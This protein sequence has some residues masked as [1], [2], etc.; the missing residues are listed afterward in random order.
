[1]NFK[2]QFMKIGNMVPAAF[3]FLAIFVA[4]LPFASRAQPAPSV[5][6]FETSEGYAPGALDGQQGWSVTQGLAAITSQDAS[7]GSQSVVLLPDTTRAK[8]AQTFTSFAGEN[9]VYVDFYTKPVVEINVNDSTIFDM[10]GARIS[11]GYDGSHNRVQ[12]MYGDGQGG[13]FW[14]DLAP[15]LS[16]DSNHQTQDWIRLTARLDFAHQTWDV[17]VNGQMLFADIPFSDN[18]IT[19]FTSFVATGDAAASSGLDHLN[20]STVNPMFDDTN[21]DGIDDA[22]EQQYGMNLSVDDRSDDPDNDGY[23]NVWEYINGTS[24]TDYYNDAL[25]V[26]RPLISSNG[27]LGPQGLATVLVTDVYGYPLNN[28]PLVFSVTSGISQLSATPGGTA[29]TQMSVNTNSAGLAQAYVGFI[30][31]SSDTLAVTAQSGSQTEMVP[32]GINSSASTFFYATDF[33]NAEGYTVGS[34]DGQ[35]GW[36]VVQ[37][38]ASVTDQSSSSGSQSIVL[39]PGAIPS[40]IIRAFPATTGENAIYVSFFAQPVAETSIT[41][42][43]SF[44][45]GGARFAFTLSDPDHAVLQV[46]NGDGAGGGSWAR[47]LFTDPVDSSSHQL[48]DMVH[49]TVRLDFT[50]KRWD[51]YT[52]NNGGMAAA[53]LGFRDNSATYLSSFAVTGDAGAPTMIDDILIAPQNPLFA[54]V[55]NDGIDDPWEQQYGLSLSTDDREGDPDG[56]GIVNVQEYVRGSDPTRFNLAIDFEASEGYALGSLDGQQ[57]WAVT[58]GSAMVTGQYASSGSHSIVLQPST[59]TVPPARIVRTFSAVTG[60]NVVYVDFYTT[61]DVN[62]K[63][64]IATGAI[65]DIG[66]ARFTFQ[67]QYGDGPDG[68]LYAFSGNGAGGGRW[69]DSGYDS[70]DIGAPGNGRWIHFTVRLDYT[71]ETW[72]LY[73]DGKMYLADMGLRDASTYL[74]SFAVTGSTRSVNF[75]T[76]PIYL[77][78]ISITSANPLFADANN[79]GINDAWEQQYGLSLASD[80]R[81]VSPNGSQTVLQ[82]Y[83]SGADPYADYYNGTLPGL[84]SLVDSSGVPGPQGLV[85]VLVTGSTGAPLANAPLIFRVASGTAWIAATPGGVGSTQVMVTTNS[86][87]VAQAYASFVSP[88]GPAVLD[89]IAQSGSQTTSLPIN[90]LP[91]NGSAL[92]PPSNLTATALSST[93]VSLGW[94]APAILGETYLIERS[95]DGV[96]FTQAAVPDADTAGYIDTGLAAG[97]SYFYRIWAQG[98]AGA[99]GYSNTVSVTTPPNGT[100][101]PL[102]PPQGVVL[103]LKADT[104]ISRVNGSGV[105]I[106]PDQSGLGNDAII[107]HSSNHW[108]PPS[109]E[110]TLLANGQNGRPVVH[111]SASKQQYFALPN[112]MMS[113]A[114]AGE[115]FVV[116]RA[117]SNQSS[118]D[119]PI[120]LLG[121]DG[122]SSYGSGG[123]GYPGYNGRLRE[124][125]GTFSGYDVGVP[126][127]DLTT[128]NL[129]NISSSASSW[130]ARL[131][132]SALTVYGQD[133]RT[134][135]YSPITITNNT[136]DFPPN[137]FLGGYVNGSFDGDIAEVIVYNRVLSTAERETVRKYLS[138]RY[139]L[140]PQPP[141]FSPGPGVYGSPFSVTLTPIPAGATIYYTT[142]GSDPSPSTSLVYGSPISVTGLTH[143]KAIGVLN[144]QTSGIADGTFNV[145]LPSRPETPTSGFAATYYHASNFSGSTISRL[146]PFIN[147]PAGSSIPAGVGSAVWTGT[148]TAQFT[149]S[150]TFNITSD[151]NPRLWVGGTLVIDGSS[152]TSYQKLSGTIS[153]VQGQTYPVRLEYVVRSSNSSAERLSLTWS[154][155]ANFAEESVPL[156]QVASGLP[157]AN[158]AST[159]SASPAG[160]SLLDGSGVTLSTGTPSTAHIYYTLD[161]SDPTNSS[162]L[163]TAPIVLHSSVTIKARA[164][165][166]SYNDSGVL[167]ASY[168]VDRTGPVL[169]SLTFNN[170]AVPGVI[171]VN[172][173]LGITATSNVGVQRVEFRLDGQLI[174]TDT[175]AA[176][177]FTVPIAILPISDGSHALNIQAWD[178]LGLASD[179]FTASITTALPSPAAPVITAPADGTKVNTNSITV[180]GTA[181]KNSLV[182]VYDG[183]NSVGTGSAGANGVFAINVPLVAGANQLKATAQNRNP[184]PSGFSTVI[185]VTYDNA[186]P[187]PPSAVSALAGAGGTVQLSWHQPAG[188]VAASG[189]YLFRSTAPIPGDAVI[190]PANALGGLL[191]GLS[192]KDTPP[193]DG[194]YYYRLVTSHAVGTSETL[195][196]LSNQVD[197][198]ADSTPPSATGS[199]QPMGSAF[200]AAGHRLG[201]GL[202]QVTLTASEPLGATPFFNFSIAGGGAIAVNLSAAGNNTYT[203]LFTISSSTPSG[204]LTPVFSAIDAV[205][206]RGSVITLDVPWAIDTAGPKATGLTPVQID[207]S[208]TVQDLP[209][210]DAIRN[211]PV[212]PATAVT[213]SWRLTLDEAPKSGTTPVC[214]ATLSGHPNLTLPVTVAG[215]SDG[216]LHTW[217]LTLTLPSDAGS[218]TE[219]L[220]LAYTVSD[221]LGNIGSTITSPHVFQVY[222]GNL[223]PLAVPSGLAATA[224]PAGAIHLAWNAI[225]TASAYVLQVKGPTDTDFH[226]LAVPTG[227]TTDYLYT[228]SADGT[229]SYQIASVRSE[230]GQDSNSGWS[231]PVSARSD[232]VPPDAPT[233]F[234]LQ[235]ISQ[236]VKASWTTPVN[237]PEDVAGYAL[238]RSA[239]A[240]TSIDSLTP[241]LANIP[242]AAAFAVDSSPNGGMPYYALVAFDAAGNRSV[243]VTG[244]A[245]VGLLPVRTLHVAQTDQAAPVLSWQQASGSVIDGY[246]LLVNNVLVSV[247]GSTLLPA[248]S[249][250]YTDQNYQSGDRAYTVRTVSGPSSVNRSLVLPGV[251]IS[252][253]SDAKIIRGLVGTINVIVQNLSTTTSITDAH[254]DLIVAGRHHGAA[255]LI[256][257][258]PGAQQTVPVVVGGYADVPSGTAPVSAVLT[259]MPNDGEQVTLTRSLN[260]NVME[261]AFTAQIIPTNMV[262]GGAGSITFQLTNPSDQPI[263]FKVAAQSGSQPSAE[264]RIQ[265]QDLRGS[266]LSTTPLKIVLGDDVVL[267]PDGTTVVRIPAG[268]T[269]VSPPIQVSIPLNA[270][271]VVNVALGI[272]SVYY[273]FGESDTQVTLDGPSVVAQASTRVAPY[274]GQITSITP[275][276]SSGMAPIV[277]QGRALWSGIDP[278]LPSALAT[279]V[280]LGLYIKNGGFVL[281][282]TVTT[283]SSGNFSYTYQPGAAEKGGVYSVWA[284]HPTVTA[285]PDS[286]S[287]FTIT[288]IIVSPQA[289]NL[290]TPRNYTQAI[291]VQVS[292]GP[293]TTV[294]NL[295]AEL[296][297]TL[298]EAV[299]VTATP[300]ATVGQNQTLTLP[301]SIVG[302]APTVTSLDSG[303]LNFHVVSDVPGGGEL[304]WATV[305]VDYQFSNAEPYLQATPS[306]LQIG[307][308]PGSVGS[309]SLDLKNAGLS[310]LDSATFSLVSTDGSAVPSWIRL[311]SP[312]TLGSLDVGAD[313]NAIVTVAP[314]NTGQ[315]ID[316]VYHLNLHVSADNDTQN[317]PVT[318]TVSPSGQGGAIFHLID[319][320]FHFAMP[321]GSSNPAFDGLPGA[322]ISL[323][324]ESSDGIPTFSQGATTDSSGE[325]S[326]SNLPAGSYKLRITADKH[327]PYTGR[328]TV[329]PGVI[330]SQQILLDYSP[331]SF[332]WT[333]V[334]VTIQDTYNIVL[335]A[336]YETKVP[337]PVVILEPAS[338]TLPPMCAGQTATGEFRATN[339]GLIDAQQ[340]TIQVPPNDANFSYELSSNFG[341]RIPAGQ[342]VTITYKVT[343]LQP[344]PGKCPAVSASGGGDGG[345]GNCGTYVAPGSVNSVDPCA[346]GDTTNCYTPFFFTAAWGACAPPPPGPGPGPGAASIGPGS[347][348]NLSGP[349]SFGN[350]VGGAGGSGDPCPP[351]PGPPPPPPPPPPPNPPPPNPPPPPCQTSCCQGNNGGPPPPDNNHL[352]PVKSWVDLTS[353][354]FCD[355]ATDLL[356]VV[357]DGHVSVWRD[358]SF[359]RWTFRTTD[360][361]YAL[362]N[363]AQNP[364]VCA[365]VINGEYYLNPA[366]S[367][368]LSQGTTIGVPQYVEGQTFLELGGTRPGKIQA[369]NGLFVWTDGTGNERDYDP[370]TAHLV[371]VRLRGLVIANYSY[372]GSGRL[373]TV[374]DRNGRTVFTFAYSGSSVNPASVTDVTGRQ[375]G[376]TYD[377]VGRL[378]TVTDVVGTV[379]T[380]T[381]DNWSNIT[382]KQTHIAD[383]PTSQDHIETVTYQL[384]TSMPA[385]PTVPPARVVPGSSYFSDV[386]HGQVI[387]V[388]QNTGRELIINYHYNSADQTYYVKTTTSE[389]VVTEFVFD[390]NSNLLSKLVNGQQVYAMQQDATTRVIARGSNQTTEQYDSLGNVVRRIYPDQTFEAYEYDP[391]VNRVS[392]YT[393]QLGTVTT[394]T[395]DAMGNELTRTEAVGT[396]LERVTTNTY[397]PGTLHLKLHTDPLGRQTEYEYDSA[398]HVVHEYDPA[399]PAHQ[400]TYTYDAL[401]YMATQTDALGGVTTYGHDSSGLL[402]SETDP[403]QQQT[404]Y[405]YQGANLV[406]VETGRTTSAPGRIMRYEYDAEGRRTKEKRVDAQGVETV[407]K[408]YTYDNDGRLVA[409]TNAL[410]QSITYG[411]DAFGNQNVVSQPD[412]DGGLSSTQTNYDALGRPIETI[413]PLGTSAQKTYDSRDHVVKLIEAVGTPVERSTSYTY[414]A[415]GHPLTVKYTD[416]REPNRTYTTAYTYDALGRRTS[417]SG[418]HS[419][420][421]TATYDPDDQLTTEADALDRVMT[422]DY[423]NYGHV[424]DMKL[425]GVMIQSYEYDLIGNKITETNGVGDHVHYHYD[426]LNRLTEQSIPLPA[427]QTIPDN[428][429]TQPA[430]ILQATTY[431]VWGEAATTTRYTVNGT[432]VQSAVTTDVYD[433]F[434]RKNN[435]TDP[436]GLNRTFSY[437]MADNL[438]TVT[439]PP[440]A[441]SGSTLPTT[442][443]YL[444]SSNNAALVDAFEDRAGNITYFAYDEALRQREVTTSLGGVTDRIFDALNRTTTQTDPAGTTS[445][446]YDLFDH[447]VKITYPD[448]VVVTHERI[449]TFSYDNLGQLVQQAGAGDYPMTYAYDALG[450]C[451][452]MTDA[453]NHQTQWSY[454]ARN[455]V[456]TKTYADGTSYTYAYDNAGRLQTRLDA[457][458]RTTTY[459]FN[460]Y[461]LPT[462]ITYPTD[463]AV[464]FTYDQQGLPLSMTDGSGTTTWIYD[465]LGRPALETQ[466]SSH[467]T[468]TYSYDSESQRIGM[469]VT[470]TDGGT[471]WQTKYG[472]DNAGRLQ[473]VLD[474][475]LPAAQPYIYAYAANSNLVSQITTPTGL[476]ETKSYDNLGRL[477]NISALNA[478]Q[479]TINS[480][481]YT[482]DAASQRNTETTPDYQQSF[483][484]DAQREL[485]QAAPQTTA[486]QRPAYQFSFDGIGNRLTSSINSGSG[487]QSISYTPNVVNQYTALAGVI[488]DTPSY[489]LNGN[490]TSVQGMTLRYDEENRLVEAS[491][492][493]HDSIYVYDGLGRRVERQDSV[494]GIQT[495]LV[496]Y[497]YDGRRAIEELDSGFATRRSYT[498]G[499]D[500]SGSLEGAGGIGGLLALSL[501]NGLA[502]T[503]A[504]YFYDGNGNVIDLVG[505]DDSS[506]A[507]YQYSPFGERL[508]ATG[509]LTDINPYQFSSK[510]CDV[511]TG[512]S[513]YG[514]RYYNPGTGRWLSRD[515]IQER[516][517][518]N[519]YGFVGNDSINLVDAFGLYTYED[520]HPDLNDGCDGS[521]T[522]AQNVE[523]LKK[524]L[525]SALI[526]LDEDFTDEFRALAEK[527]IPHDIPYY[528]RRGKTYLDSWDGHVTYLLKTLGASAKCLFILKAQLEAGK[529]CPPDQ[530]KRNV[531]IAER[532]WARAQRRVPKPIIISPVQAYENEMENSGG[533]L[534]WLIGHGIIGPPMPVPVP[535]Y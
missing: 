311:G 108:Q 70:S 349:G 161:G 203:G 100:D 57:G 184:V 283:D 448:H 278:A 217:L 405:T 397:Y 345:G 34:L 480:F 314:P 407:F 227:T 225:P 450:N 182:T 73:A 503:T 333:V 338:I 474:S 219:N 89:A 77:D 179:V 24:P 297:G 379:T 180:R 525:K 178:N 446:E 272:D 149:D 265:V 390:Q 478:Q 430:Y 167:V 369:S 268:A 18:T 269:Y 8:I 340:V 440:V 336:T 153:L 164:V 495:S 200:D 344:L 39:Q 481:A 310:T 476:K 341:D 242:P 468:L 289:F 305:T 251:S 190:N 388:K 187:N 294:Q 337:V 346:N 445:Y 41:T 511:G 401:G 68:E 506:Q 121:G 266:L 449:E 466:G 368:D 452:S 13:G 237:H 59:G 404:L 35:Q 166:S 426:V 264:A 189:Y 111:F 460:A 201:Q 12:V 355:A 105:P 110:P 394:Y 262:S 301:L 469:G 350:G 168:T 27:Q 17:Y 30:S 65:F 304:T 526:R 277:I 285:Q 192:Y 420:A 258:A 208:G 212:A 252:L 416:V 428:W 488:N 132:G 431:T 504:N 46:F 97:T 464:A 255:D 357:P 458:G 7:S 424:L 257:L 224:Q 459:S 183:A 522:C 69:L 94:T 260:A 502:Y 465:A 435:E 329:Q 457:M 40:Q 229:Y 53:D 123:D 64:D 243:L 486:P 443:T 43:T 87:G 146:D 238:Y 230:N 81:S 318:V 213:V 532:I 384:Y 439:Y 20:V 45:I 516:G 62:N 250:S 400:T 444:R 327:L 256:S 48:Q 347:G 4:C 117:S 374:T 434:G 487:P 496:R 432:D 510:E 5:I 191:H 406:Q 303:E 348:I 126:P 323:D 74:S 437:D 140:G 54:D 99:S 135:A 83:I 529:C 298:P 214:T 267:L 216:N 375:V 473:S 259:I 207:S 114:S 21:N 160:G 361:F 171:T 383:T 172:G 455:Q 364:A 155:A 63:N 505:D 37:G 386:N 103:W 491:D 261:G 32:V 206:N 317:F 71:H 378:A 528:A 330:Y 55:N 367:L 143:I 360:D 363:G 282:N 366:S 169:S 517:G 222:Q 436:A 393:N 419:Y 281:Q 58:Q 524:F 263:E 371:S 313:F 218:Q 307:A 115:I 33:E 498:R 226:D 78:N 531:D 220:T 130:I 288:S 241:I 315:T 28:A 205:G 309:G 485:V 61:A 147:F 124:N 1:M 29:T 9:I 6:D 158:T 72:D 215:T 254:L 31:G 410:G 131:N 395:Y 112:Y 211:E 482:Y 234:S 79:D 442:E 414:D 95:T 501:P 60:E 186:V 319:P 11:F 274:A 477:T 295:R 202:V 145:G 433:A 507:H 523:R 471:P 19:S 101:M 162:A 413:D 197:A 387:D 129:Y 118:Q 249:T 325:A 275:S 109:D 85:S 331:I 210:F 320:Y 382:T 92:S 137:L 209:V 193:S 52:A 381:Y 409:E 358:F 23:S 248:S 370:A 417:I 84:A 16:T 128:F 412:D 10:G 533:E 25:P 521:K 22:W 415:L 385:S 232:R 120:Y 411:Y 451:I 427:T 96:H 152:Q 353:R 422:F 56:D 380:Y 90:I 235:V 470:S 377:S 270:P 233:A 356:V 518:L 484:Y 231:D 154:S 67:D 497:V 429:W 520:K 494:N 157:Y 15:Y 199:L 185:T 509:L 373:S 359:D 339:H 176:D 276:V 352:A 454:T 403:L 49:F 246:N 150:Y 296:V 104:G 472:Y 2:K 51:I 174:G 204:A 326:F 142:D 273:N 493:T 527:Q 284:S 312:A 519:V 456:Q 530:L 372:D 351:P 462:G 300:L 438:V 44:D 376:Y 156:W 113:G 159:P 228:P 513:Y 463:P 354:E 245:N 362:T 316:Q 408:T 490:T 116:V 198:V 91:T 138:L 306:S 343:C 461:G 50:H 76:Y 398:G 453:N 177:G 148:L 492:A 80:D 479:A 389:G 82:D 515:P 287:T 3:R 195:S 75:G 342:T 141:V 475:R 86:S 144:S 332:N 221:D 292:T 423:D 508:N 299:S 127:T 36:S 500:L 328:I 165:A 125:F 106:W 107:Y 26:I 136:V 236:G 334:P 535:V 489:D 66:G 399:N 365:L 290:R 391:I 286:P 188:G 173:A 98:Y 396:P 447:Q 512:F 163:Y 293:G 134:G 324:K 514:Q 122:Y 392:K 302:L 244:F 441:S 93:Q 240:I 133:W 47:T 14:L 499:L 223:P 196:A 247:S 170:A 271:A 253:A 42:A 402:Q 280:P 425:N 102:A 421:K 139:A 335:T 88:A 151:G 483:T 534:N 279:G 194:H 467:R 418:D 239:T 321:D 38:S 181:E 308:Q 175:T 322:I 119:N 291:P